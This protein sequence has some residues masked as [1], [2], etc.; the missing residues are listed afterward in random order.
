M[1]RA[2]TLFLLP[3]ATGRHEHE[4]GVHMRNAVS[5]LTGGLA[6]GLVMAW[7]TPASIA[8]QGST[9]TPAKTMAPPRA[10]AP[11]TGPVPKTVDGHPNL[12]GVWNFNTSTPFE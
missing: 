2:G 3:R 4:G 1:L 6:I 11:M 7:L 5:S 8:G 9:L 12:Q 10:A